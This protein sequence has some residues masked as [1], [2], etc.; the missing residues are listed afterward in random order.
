MELKIL[1]WQ[2]SDKRELQI[3]FSVLFFQGFPK[4]S[5]LCFLELH[6]PC[7][8]QILRAPESEFFLFFFRNCIL[9]LC[10]L[11]R[12]LKL[13][14][15]FMEEQKKH[16]QCTQLISLFILIFLYIIPPLE[17]VQVTPILFSFVKDGVAEMGIKM[18][19]CESPQ[20]EGNEG[21]IAKKRWIKISKVA[22][23]SVKF[24]SPGINHSWKIL[25]EISC[26]SRNVCLEFLTDS[27]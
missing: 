4:N 15:Y 22:P 1:F 3:D 11:K 7:C 20:I 25:S 21:R 12:R 13:I 6:R 18:F 26:R 8:L 24:F 19:S 10:S 16:L 17:S 14:Q 23:I 2:K 9:I 5:F 27:N